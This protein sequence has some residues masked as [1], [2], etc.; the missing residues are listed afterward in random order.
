MKYIIKYSFFFSLVLVLSSC[1]DFLIKEPVTEI[2]T[3]NFWELK[4]DAEAALVGCYDALQPDTYYGFDLYIYG[5]VR[6][7]NCLAGGDS[8]DIF[9]IEAF[10]EQSTNGNV[11]RTWN[12]LYSAISRTNIVLS[13][14]QK[15]D[16]ILFDPGQ[17]NQILGEAYGLRALHYF[18]LVRLWG[19]VP[20]VLRETID[21][22]DEALLV[23]KSPISTVYERIILDF[24]QAVN[25][26]PAQPTAAGRLSKGV[27]EAFLAKVALTQQ[28]YDGVIFWTDKVMGRGYSLIGTYDFLFDQ[29]H[30]NNQEVLLSVQYA[31]ENEGNVFPELVLP[32]PEASFEFIK[33]NTPTENSRNQFEEGDV[34]AASAFVERN[35]R[36]Y[37]YK[38]RNG[39]A[40]ASEDNNVILRYADVLL[41]RAEALNQIG[42]TA[43][44]I[45]LL[46]RIR[47]RAGLGNYSG[48]TAVVEVDEAI[49]QERRVELMY[50]GHRWFD[51]RRRGLQKVNEA[52]STA[53]NITVTEEQLF[54]PIPQDEIDRNPNLNN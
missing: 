42:R 32:T 11:A 50:E 21:I 9:A 52:L 49:F 4:Q 10:T 12:S 20:L 26:L 16:S 29:E 24:E 41:M 39:E 13:R 47:S 19:S 45:D 22:S 2:S 15:M 14:V 8:P 43:E 35:G 51:L 37:L 53:K 30:K 48:S 36:F 7:D 54:F 34:R 18:N 1:E 40:F 38:W 25:L 17:K 31:G 6:A 5:D 44:A 27:A 23:S 46:N 33:F 3:E 28:D